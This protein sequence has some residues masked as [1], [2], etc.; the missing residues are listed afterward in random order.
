MEYNI[1][2]YNVKKVLGQGGSSKVLLVEDSFGNQYAL[3]ALRRDKKYTYE[4]GLKLLKREHCITTRVENHPNILNSHFS[5]PD[6]VLAF[7]TNQEQIMY[8]LIEYAEN[9]ALSSYIRITGPIEEN[10]VRFMFIQMCDAI[11]FIHSK[12]VA[13]L[14]LK[15][16][17][18]LLDKFFN[19]KLADLGVAHQATK[20]NKNWDH[21]KGTLNYMAPEVN[22]LKKN[23]NFDVFKADIYSLGVC[24][25]ILLIGDFPDHSLI[26][27]NSIWTNDSD[28]EDIENPT[29]QV[30]NNSTKKWNSLS[31][32]V[33]NLIISMLSNQPDQRPSI[34]GVLNH[35]WLSKELD[36]QILY[37]LSTK[38]I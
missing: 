33:K 17:N 30:E 23:E 5:N 35:K 20:M 3:K 34:E 37:D 26:T 24:L 8:N 15:L 16:E 38:F 7:G 31:E 9:G 10:L 18:I 4:R 11:W 2:N 25:Y 27:S 12:L 32:S 19:I 36:D 28:M 6:G 29:K 14:D 21:R 1:D 22:N 13:H